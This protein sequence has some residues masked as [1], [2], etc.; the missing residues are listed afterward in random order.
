MTSWVSLAYVIIALFVVGLLMYIMQKVEDDR[1]SRTD[2]IWLQWVRRFAFVSTSL[3]LLY[4][5]QSIDWQLTCFLLVTASA[6]VLFIN[7]LALSLRAPPNNKGRAHL[8]SFKFLYP[9]RILLNYL[10]NVI[11]KK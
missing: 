1:W 10:S 4:S 7:A 6:V 11:H 8:H 2:P 3:I 9:Y 5:I